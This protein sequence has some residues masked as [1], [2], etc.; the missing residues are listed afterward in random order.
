MTAAYGKGG[1]PRI[2]KDDDAFEGVNTHRACL[3]A[4][5]EEDVSCSGGPRGR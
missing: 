3:K 5:D 2:T 1:P 4:R